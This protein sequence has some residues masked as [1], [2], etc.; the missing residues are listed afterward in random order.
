MCRK[1]HNMLKKCKSRNQY[2]APQECTY[3][4]YTTLCW[5]HHL[6]SNA[7]S[8]VSVLPITI[9][10]SS[11][12]GSVSV[13]IRLAFAK[14]TSKSHS[15][16][17]VTSYPERNA[18]VFRWHISCVMKRRTTFSFCIFH[19]CF[20]HRGI[21]FRTLSL[22]H[23]YWLCFPI[24]RAIQHRICERTQRHL[25]TPVTWHVHKQ[26]KITVLQSDHT[27]NEQHAGKIHSR[28]AIESMWWPKCRYF[29]RTMLHLQ[30]RERQETQQN[31]S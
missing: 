30:V 15:M 23:N 14:N 22:R 19:G 7:E 4:L 28:N 16:L 20:L 17:W 11:L 29:Y 24:G 18:Y 10:F 27:G 2:K 26:D 31:L 13:M 25:M 3:K 21:R 6:A 9:K 12:T 1:R 8:N 5:K